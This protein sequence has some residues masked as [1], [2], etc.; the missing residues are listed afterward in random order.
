M[1]IVSDDTEEVGE[2]QVK[3]GDVQGKTPDWYTPAVNDNVEEKDCEFVGWT[4]NDE[5]APA[6]YK[7]STTE[8]NEVVAAYQIPEEDQEPPKVE[9]TNNN[10]SESAPE[11]ESPQE[12][13]PEQV[14]TQ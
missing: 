5:P 4:V 12:P 8:D 7:P 1:V 13:A 9:E 11:E 10:S 14:V 2:R 3:L 6:D